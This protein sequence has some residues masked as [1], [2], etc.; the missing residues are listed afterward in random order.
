[1]IPAPLQLF[2]YFLKPSRTILK[3]IHGPLQLGFSEN[4][5]EHARNMLGVFAHNMKP[6]YHIGEL[7]E[8][9]LVNSQ[10]NLLAHNRGLYLYK[11]S[12]QNLPNQRIVNDIQPIIAILT[13]K[14]SYNRPCIVLHRFSN[15][16]LYLLNGKGGGVLQPYKHTYYFGPQEFIV[17][18]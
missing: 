4:L 13:K 8:R 11:Y 1:M 10:L 17:Y 5:L 9:G 16:C 2:W 7:F 12:Q 15:K 18:H 3:M 6:V 14:N